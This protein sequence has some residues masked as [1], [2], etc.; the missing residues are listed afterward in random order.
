[1][2]KG[3]K[4]L[5]IIL[6]VLPFLIFGAFQLFVPISRPNT[7]VRNYILRKIPMGTSW[8]NAVEI[9]DK[10]KWLIKQKDVEHG[11]I[12]YDSAGAVE[13]ATDNAIKLREKAPSESRIAGAKSMFI[14]LGEFYGPFHTAVFAYLAFNENNELVEITIRRDIDAP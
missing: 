4:R 8:D 3:I 5:L 2:K 11:L 7:Q 10:K 12:I 6:V 9:I 13:F 14:E 1:M